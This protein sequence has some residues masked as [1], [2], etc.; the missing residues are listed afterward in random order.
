MRNL[1]IGMLLFLTMAG[2]A[3][4]RAHVSDNFWRQ[5]QYNDTYRDVQN[6]ILCARR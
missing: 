2:A 5:L 3:Q 6:Q 1:V 4:A